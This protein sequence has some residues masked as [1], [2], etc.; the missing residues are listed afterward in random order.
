MSLKVDKKT[1]RVFLATFYLYLGIST[2]FASEELLT[3][4]K[5]KNNLID[6]QNLNGPTS[7]TQCKSNLTPEC[8]TVH[9]TK[10]CKDQFEKIKT[11]KKEKSILEKIESEKSVLFLAEEHGDEY[12]YAYYEKI[13][14]A[15]KFD[16]LFIE[17]PH[18]FQKNF[19]NK[20]EIL[21]EDGVFMN[22]NKKK[23]FENISKIELKKNSYI[24]LLSSLREV[25]KENEVKVIL[26]DSSK[27][28]VLQKELKDSLKDR[29]QEMA[30][31]IQKSFDENQCQNGVSILGTQHLFAENKEKNVK[32]VDQFLKENSKDIKV[33][34]AMLYSPNSESFKEAMGP[35]SWINE[36]PKEEESYFGKD[37]FSGHSVFPENIEKLMMDVSEVSATNDADIAIMLPLVLDKDFLLKK[38]NE[39]QSRPKKVKDEKEISIITEPVPLVLS[40]NSSALGITWGNESLSS[41]CIDYCDS[42]DLR[43][44]YLVKEVTP[45]DPVIKCQS[46]HPSRTGGA[47]YA[48]EYMNRFKVTIDCFCRKSR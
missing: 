42:K 48:P 39:G 27:K 35:C 45:L 36:L 22:L 16:C 47:S 25:A 14:K 46:Y 15:K 31:N 18:V 30:Q 21:Q 29:N 43:S 5:L 4:L 2:T 8:P 34:K 38:L 24:E 19:D 6:L 1:M 28:S 32:P 10:W 26:V 13:L 37:F 11:L 7:P 44:E 33:T 9:V 23:D 3:H 12:A 40:S 41:V 20:K 17:L